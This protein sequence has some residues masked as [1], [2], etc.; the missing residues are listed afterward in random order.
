MSA[1]ELGAGLALLLI[2]IAAVAR[3]AGSAESIVLAAHNLPWA[4]ALLVWSSGLIR[5]DAVPASSMLV[6]ACGI[7]SFNVGAFA[8]HVNP[9]RAAA[10]QNVKFQQILLPRRTYVGLWFGYA[11]GFVWLL[12]T[13]KHYFGLSVLLTN[14]R[15]IRTYSSIDYLQKFPL[16][17]KLLFY[18]APLLMAL[19]ANPALVVG[20][21]DRP[22]LARYTLYGLLIVTQFASL[23]RTNIFVGIVW[24]V[25][26][27]LM[28]ARTNHSVH[29]SSAK[30]SG[31]PGTRKRRRRWHVAVAGVV[32]AVICFQLLGSVLGKT[33]ST[34]VRYT[35]YLASSV[36][37]EP[38]ASALLYGSSG[39]EGFLALTQSTNHAWPPSVQPPI[40]GN[41]N[42]MTYGAATF[43]IIPKF[44]PLFMPWPE[45]GPFINVPFPTNVY[46][47]LDPWYRDF[48]APGVALLAFAIGFAATSFVR[49][50][51]CSVRG[52]LLAG[53]IVTSIV[54]AP[55]TNR[56]LSTMTLELGIVVYMLC[57]PR[58]GDVWPVSKTQIDA[59]HGAK[60]LSRNGTGMMRIDQRGYGRP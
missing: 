40:Y 32:G 8:S 22:R 50:R 9:A 54:W 51:R 27:A 47:W 12:L 10:V 41:Y 60:A 18:L 26:V 6:L 20:L 31:S 21:A 55:F 19:T 13:I 37:K 25:A 24:S 44:I 39:I 3:I 48:R 43:S 16:P 17:G 30:L 35:P 5:Y 4:V 29:H 14:P 23:Q 1:T 33:T 52:L 34:D 53:L 58:A 2:A 49:R 7:V 46:T 42:P 11:T 28:G 57:R 15:I 36:N 59:D 38:L 45:V 56:I